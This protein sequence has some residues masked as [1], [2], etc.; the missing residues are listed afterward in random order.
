MYCSPRSSPVLSTNISS[1]HLR[2]NPLGSCC[3]L[4]S[5]YRWE[6]WRQRDCGTCSQAL[7]KGCSQDWNLGHLDSL[8]FYPIS[9]SKQ[10]RKKKSNH[11]F[12]FDLES[13]LKWK[14]WEKRMQMSQT[15]LSAMARK[16]SRKLGKDP[17]IFFSVCI[18]ESSTGSCEAPILLLSL[19]MQLDYHRQG[20]WLLNP[21]DT[22]I[23]GEIL[24]SL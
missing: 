3:P 7:K 23:W 17:A 8:N 1:F 12:L 10:S 16:A 5:Y 9:L 15:D 4:V 14:G 21:K 19:V 11:C 20:R 18:T 6:N 13:S 22:E 24:V 2:N